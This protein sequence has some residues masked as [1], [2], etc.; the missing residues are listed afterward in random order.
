MS[1]PRRFWPISGG[2]L[3]RAN[4]AGDWRPTAAV[5]CSGVFAV[6]WST[7]RGEWWAPLHDFEPETQLELIA[8][9]GS[10]SVAL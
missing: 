7:P 2:R 9:C 1:A 3:S 8:A 10:A 4:I 6:A 5:D